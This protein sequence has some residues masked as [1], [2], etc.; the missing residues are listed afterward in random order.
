MTI[1]LTDIRSAV[2]DYVN[3]SV[4]TS[5]SSLVADVPNAISPNEG[6]TFSVTASNAAA[7]TGIQLVNVVYHLKVAS[8]SVAKLQVPTTPIARS[9]SRTSDPQLTVGNY[10]T[11]MY[12]FP[13]DNVLEVGDSDTV[14]GLRGKAYAVGQATIT[15]EVYADIDLGFVFPRTTSDPDSIRLVNVV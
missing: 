3:D 7:P 2:I 1:N 14:A 8:G 4:T 9:G 6:F 10:V 12:L 13:S 11:E 15:F 5:V